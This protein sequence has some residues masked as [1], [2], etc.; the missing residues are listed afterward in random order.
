MFG[1]CEGKKVMLVKTIP[2]MARA[3]MSRLRFVNQRSGLCGWMNALASKAEESRSLAAIQYWLDLV[4]E[5]AV[6][7]A[8]MAALERVCMK[9]SS[10]MARNAVPRNRA[11]R[12]FDWS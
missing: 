10:P 4:V 5:L 8:G 1:T 6:M 11:C 2:Q 9:S 7:K 3:A 12:S